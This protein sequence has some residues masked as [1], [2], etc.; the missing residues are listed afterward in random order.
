MGDITRRN[1]LRTGGAVGAMSA[2]TLMSPARAWAWSPSNSIAGTGDGADPRWVWDEVADPLMA[3][4]IERGDVPLVNRLLANWTKNSQPL[5]AGLPAD[6][7]AFI[8]QARQLPS[9]ADQNKLAASYTFT[10]KRGLYLGVLYGMGSGMISTAIPHE[11]RA[12]YWSKGGADLKDR[13]AKTAKLGYDIGVKDAFGPNGEMIVTCVKTRM[14]HAAVRHLLPQSPFWQQSADQTIPISQRDMMVT[15]NSLASFTWQKLTSWRLNIP[16][17]EQAGYLHSWQLTGHMLGIRDEYIPSSWTNAISQY[18]EVLDPILGPTAEGIELA[19]E[20]L[21]LAAN[22]DGG[23][24]SY[25]L[26]AGAA[27]YMLGDQIANYLKIKDNPSWDLFFR[28]GWPAFVAFREAAL[29]LPFAPAG[30]WTF[31]EFLRRGA[32]WFLNDGATINITIPEG[33]RPT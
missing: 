20:L 22:I 18:H 23:V 24:M 12:V 13:I 8:E 26:L 16:A 21:H 14:V 27:R 28:T 7:H 6:V 32:L 29:P 17:A 5:P 1:V 15:W 25:P 31:D 2:L 30:Y 10:T 4:V 3:D 11:A 9:W 19:D 33:N